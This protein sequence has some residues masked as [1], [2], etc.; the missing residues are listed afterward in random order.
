MSLPHF[1][2]FEIDPTEESMP[3]GHFFI[4]SRMSRFMTS[5]RGIMK[6]TELRNGS[7]FSE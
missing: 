4:V 1:F 2:F 7:I 6:Q 5:G 3:S